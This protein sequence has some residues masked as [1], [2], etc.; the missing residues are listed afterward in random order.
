MRKFIVTI[1]EQDP[2]DI[3]VPDLGIVTLILSRSFDIG[4]K[5]ES[6]SL[7]FSGVVPVNGKEEIWRW[8][9]QPLKAGDRVTVEITAGAGTPEPKH[10]RAAKR[11]EYEER[12]WEHY[13]ELK[14]KFEGKEG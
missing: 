4:E 12:E 1:N 9:D 6:L 11:Q 8:I 7:D 5:E 10:R 2:V 13:L 3:L 14:E